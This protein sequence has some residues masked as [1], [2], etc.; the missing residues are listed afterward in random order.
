[1]MKGWWP[2]LRRSLL[3]TPQDDRDL[4]DEIA[5]HLTQERL[6]RVGLG[7]APGEAARGARLELGSAALVKERTRAIWVSSA[8]EQLFQ[9]LRYGARI[10]TKSPGVS[11]ITDR[12]LSTRPPR[13]GRGS[14]GGAPRRIMVLVE[15]DTVLTEGLAPLGLPHTLNWFLR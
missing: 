13:G 2:R 6:R 3:R 14:V 1:M 7:V 15:P 9:D 11:G 12:M 4:D 5:F 10:L 8:L